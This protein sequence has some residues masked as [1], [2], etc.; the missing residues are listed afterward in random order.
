MSTVMICWGMGEGYG[1]ANKIACVTG[2]L[3]ATGLHVVIAARDRRLM[4]RVA[5]RRGLACEVV[6][7]PVLPATRSPD[8][9]TVFYSDLLLSR[10][11]SD[12][13]RLVE[14][15]AGWRALFERHAPDVI[16]F[17]YAP[18]AI[19]AAR[20]VDT[21]R[22]G[23]GTGFYYPPAPLPRLIPE[24]M[25]GSGVAHDAGYDTA[26]E[27]VNQALHASGLTPVDGL[28]AVFDPGP[29]FITGAPEVDHFGHIRR[30]GRYTGPVSENL[31]PG[32]ALEWP[33][34]K[35]PRIAGY[36][37]AGAPGIERVLLRLNRVRA[38]FVLH[39]SPKKGERP[40]ALARRLPRSTNVQITLRPFD[41]DAMARQASC[42]VCHAGNGATIAS[43]MAG[44]P[45]FGL[46]LHPEQGLQVD[47]LRRAGL[48]DGTHFHAA[49]GDIGERILALTRHGSRERQRARNFARKYGGATP[50]PY[51]ELVSGVA[52][53]AGGA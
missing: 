9:A 35:G 18:T 23:F 28:E 24:H 41:I 14:A 46:D 7:A 26:L 32:S 11:Y 37:K 44:T 45:V 12:P 38:R 47:A 43:L 48:G 19:L 2:G 52:R 50:S 3:E 20:G 15:I 29:V 40:E 8:V 30:D 21:P 39:L 17:E 27:S 34:G 4:E 33:Q 16:A 5:R 10:G 51:R 42:F 31:S 13:D 22:L 49:A 36:L 6:Q 1:H 53:L 25:T